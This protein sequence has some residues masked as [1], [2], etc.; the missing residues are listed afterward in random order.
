MDLLSRGPGHPVVCKEITELTL[1][2]VHWPQA[3]KTSAILGPEGQNEGEGAGATPTAR[4]PLRTSDH[5]AS[6]ALS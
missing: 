2:D 1:I 5:G 3:K 6:T 4:A